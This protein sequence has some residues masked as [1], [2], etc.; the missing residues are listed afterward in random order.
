LAAVPV[1]GASA[2]ALWQPVSGQQG[3]RA[4]LAVA[5]GVTFTRC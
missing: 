1:S 3:A 5:N 4:L 2:L